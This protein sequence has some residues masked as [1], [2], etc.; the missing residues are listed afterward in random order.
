M[1]AR[2]PLIGKFSSAAVPFQSCFVF[3]HVSYMERGQVLGNHLFFAT[4]SQ[5]SHSEG[6]RTRR[7]RA[8]PTQR[9][10]RMSRNRVTRLLFLSEAA[11][12]APQ[13]AFLLCTRKDSFSN[14]AESRLRRP[15]SSSSIVADT[16]AARG[17]RAHDL[18]ASDVSGDGPNRCQARAALV[19]WSDGAVI[20]LIWQTRPRS[21][22]RVC[23]FCLQDESFGEQTVCA[24]PNFYSAASAVSTTQH[25]RQRT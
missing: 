22:Q 20:A 1:I 13:Q 3:G 11:L 15:R 17:T 19:G 7:P 23:S 21:A 4:F 6:K 9:V 2:I 16:A 8:N 18:M 25:S 10:S 12:S 14:S 5:L 24:K